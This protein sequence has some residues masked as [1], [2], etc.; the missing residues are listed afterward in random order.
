M[1]LT[2]DLFSLFNFN[3]YFTNLCIVKL[4]IDTYIL[5]SVILVLL[6]YFVI[7]SRKPIVDNLIKIE[8]GII[9]TAAVLDTTLSLN[10]R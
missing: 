7:H 10:D 1:I 2:F 3:D 6:D 5:Y 9:G 8:T 4:N